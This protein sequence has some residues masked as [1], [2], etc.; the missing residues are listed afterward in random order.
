MAYL[1]LHGLGVTKA[2]MTLWEGA[3]AHASMATAL[4]SRPLHSFV[5]SS[6]SRFTLLATRHRVWR[7]FEWRHAIAHRRP[8]GPS[9]SPGEALVFAAMLTTACVAVALSQVGA[10]AA[11]TEAAVKG[12]RIDLEADTEALTLKQVVHLYLRVEGG[13]LRALDLRGFQP[14]LKQAHVKALSVVRIERTPGADRGRVLERYKATVA[15]SVGTVSLTFPRGGGLRRGDYAIRFEHAAPAEG[16]LT[17][18]GTTLRLKYVFPPWEHDLFE[19]SVRLK[20]PPG[21][22]ALPGHSELVNV[23]EFLDDGERYATFAREHV[24][25]E[26]RWSI[27][28]TLPAG[29]LRSGRAFGASHGPGHLPRARGA[30]PTSMLADSRAGLGTR[31]RSAGGA[32]VSAKAEGSQARALDLFTP[33]LPALVLGLMLSLAFGAYVAYA[34]ARVRQRRA[35]VDLSN[36]GLGGFCLPLGACAAVAGLSAMLGC[37]VLALG[38]TWALTVVGA[39]FGL[40]LA[41]MPWRNLDTVSTWSPVSF[42]PGPDAGSALVAHLAPAGLD[43]KIP[44][45]GL[46]ARTGLRFGQRFGHYVTL[47]ASRGWARTLPWLPGCVI[48]ALLSF[49]CLPELRDWIHLPTVL[50]FA[51]LLALTP[52]MLRL[53]LERAEFSAELLR[54]GA[55]VLAQRLRQSQPLAVIDEREARGPAGQVL[56]IALALRAAD[57]GFALAVTLSRGQRKGPRVRLRLEVDPA[58]FGGNL[59]ALRQVLGKP[60]RRSRGPNAFTHTYRT[61][62]QP[63]TLSTVLDLLPPRARVTPSMKPAHGPN[64]DGHRAA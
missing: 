55:K 39:V 19:A 31:T 46:G 50:W 27:E 17:R 12:A 25:R 16:V 29:P 51:A 44:R 6:V 20:L 8:V 60:Y 26:T 14:T 63:E 33:R 28:A 43:T 22:R 53:G 62:I 5:C 58:R 49:R 37:A 32:Q 11:W 59:M 61:A 42:T 35:R 13:E 56:A 18:D 40:C 4:D 48:V 57:R 34:T 21:A 54:E 47:T 36:V 30:E 24:P 3:S 52:P 9:F 64:I 2:A 41:H 23:G 45:Q 38:F 10:A 7:A 15:Q 1:Y